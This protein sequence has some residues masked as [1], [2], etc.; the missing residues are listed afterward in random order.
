MIFKSFKSVVIFSAIDSAVCFV[1]GFF[2]SFIFSIPTGA[3][4][5]IFN[6]VVFVIC[7]FAALFKRF[8]ITLG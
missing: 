1:L 6:L 3:M 8:K 5:V 4:I 7:Y 2:S